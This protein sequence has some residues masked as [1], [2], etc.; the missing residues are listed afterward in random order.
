[1]HKR[2]IAL[3]LAVVASSVAAFVLNQRLNEERAISAQLRTRIAATTGSA[4]PSVAPTAKPALETSIRVPVR[5]VEKATDEPLPSNETDRRQD[6]QASQRQLMKDP[7]YVEAMRDQRRLSYKLR[8]DNA[9]RLFGFSPATADA[10]VNLD[11]DREIRM[12]SLDPAASGDDM[13]SQY[14]ALQRDHDAKLLALL[15]QDSFDRWQTYMET[16]ATRM[17]VDRFRAHLNGADA[18][19]EDQVEPL[20]T[21]LAAEQKQM[22]SDL[23]EYRNSLDW[24]GDATE[25]ANKFRARQLEIAKAGHK[26]MVASA[27]S[28][29]SASQAQQLADMLNNDVEQRATQERIEALRQKMG[30]APDPGA[31]D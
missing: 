7:R 26:R 5:G 18:L 20:I 27:G 29:L 4:S 17:E 19:R 31:G 1:M 16:R 6:W 3:G 2:E 23:E 24:N 13:R 10:I 21:A 14:E 15:G 9:I 11:V 8:R 12:M 22:Q 25:S 28:I 30:P